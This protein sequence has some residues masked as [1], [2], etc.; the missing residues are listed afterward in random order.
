[1]RFKIKKILHRFCT[2]DSHRGK[3]K[4][5]RHRWIHLFGSLVC[6]WGLATFFQYF[7]LFY[8]ITAVGMIEVPTRRGCAV[9][10]PFFVWIY[11]WK[12]FKNSTVAP[13]TILLLYSLKYCI[14]PF[15][16][17]AKQPLHRIFIQP[18]E[19]VA[20]TPLHRIS[21][22]QFNPNLH[23]ESQIVESWSLKIGIQ[24]APKVL[25]GVYVTV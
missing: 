23:G 7:F 19:S 6:V 4:C 22:D 10:A 8:T 12:I 17:V 3:D 25:S 5:R 20:K 13:A 9:C 24:Y 15:E 14:Q 2:R 21:N 1:M 16:S 18:F 11:E